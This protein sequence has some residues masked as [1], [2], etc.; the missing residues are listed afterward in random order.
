[1]ANR[2]S[3]TRAPG[4]LVAR[5]GGLLMALVAGK[6]LRVRQMIASAVTRARPHGDLEFEARWQAR[7]DR[8]ATRRVE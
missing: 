2:S 8:A 7:Q 6:D 1:M 5:L 4:E 3:N